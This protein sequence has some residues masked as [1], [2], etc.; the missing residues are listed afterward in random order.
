MVQCPHSKQWSEIIPLVRLIAPSSYYPVNT[1]SARDLSS[2][3]PF[4]LDF[5]LSGSRRRPDSFR[6]SQARI[7]LERMLRIGVN[8]CTLPLPGIGEGVLCDCMQILSIELRQH[9]RLKQDLSRDYFPRRATAN[10]FL[11][12]AIWS[13]GIMILALFGVCNKSGYIV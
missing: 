12:N 6:T 2:Q 8:F 5:D 10:Q 3:T 7:Q 9:A 1:S 4:E 13:N 11:V